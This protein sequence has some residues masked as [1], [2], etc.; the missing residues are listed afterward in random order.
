MSMFFEEGYEKR[1]FKLTEKL[2]LINWPFLL[3]IA[4]ITSFGV[5]ALYSVAG[6]ALDPWASRHVVRFCLGLA[7]LFAVAVSDIRWW[8][9]AAYPHVA[10]HLLVQRFLLPPAAPMGKTV[11]G[12]EAAKN[13]CASVE[14]DVKMLTESGQFEGLAAVYGVLD[15]QG[16]I[17]D[18]GAFSTSLRRSRTVPILWQHQPDEVLG[19]G[20]L[21]DTPAGLKITGTLNLAVAKAREA[22][23]LLKQRALNG[24]SIG[25]TTVRDQW[26][27][28]VRHLQELNLFEI[29]LATFPANPLAVVD[30]LKSVDGDQQGDNEAQFLALL[31]EIQAA[32]PRPGE[33]EEASM[34]QLLRTI[35]SELILRT[36]EAD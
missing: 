29:S 18:P 36:Q 34:L 20:E 5:A 14:F 31:K 4:A 25:F 21:E 24:L 33:R 10:P 15:A 27:Q 16:E 23:A 9:R 13:C 28:G 3:L 7:L 26:R 11:A 30:R 12:V 1:Q 17:V 32:L 2:I 22:Y 8:L 6:G 35:R 19:I